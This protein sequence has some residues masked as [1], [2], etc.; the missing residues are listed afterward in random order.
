MALSSK[1]EGMDAA[2]NT[3]VERQKSILAQQ[4]NELEALS[5]GQRLEGCTV[6]LTAEIE[7][8][9]TDVASKVFEVPEYRDLVDTIH[10][11]QVALLINK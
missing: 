3:S 2:L 1:T 6:A 4:Q 7:R 9:S 8:V 10:N 11:K 5:L